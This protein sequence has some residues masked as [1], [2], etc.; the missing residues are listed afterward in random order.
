MSGEEQFPRKISLPSCHLRTEISVGKGYSSCHSNNQRSRA[1]PFTLYP[2]TA[3]QLV[4]VLGCMTCPTRYLTPEQKMSL[5][6]RGHPLDIYQDIGQRN[7][8]T[9][10]DNFGFALSIRRSRLSEEAGNGVF[11]ETGVV[12]P[13]Q[14]I[15]LYPGT[16]YQPFQPVLYV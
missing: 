1:K 13:G 12:S 11:V 7:K 10:L 3:Q 15:A 6:R 16:V 4:T 8:K 14:I 5:Y 9:L 2:F